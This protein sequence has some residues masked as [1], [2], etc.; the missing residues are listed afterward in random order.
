MT[1]ETPP[2]TAGIS[3]AAKV[4]IAV[5]L[6]VVIVP[7]LVL[8]LLACLGGLFF[9]SA[10]GLASAGI[11]HT[12][13]ED[14]QRTVERAVFGLARE[15]EERRARGETVACGSEAEARDR[16]PPE[17]TKVLLDASNPSDKCLL[18]LG[19]ED[20]PHKARYWV[21]DEAHGVSDLDADGEVAR[22]SV[23]EGRVVGEPA[24]AR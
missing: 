6:L 9:A 4:I 23:R 15:V 14:Q 17:A 18:D 11:Q 19:L 13:A 10:T 24:G 21:D 22:W 8:A 20:V 1:D 3:T 7:P 5:V 12:V 2:K 16:L